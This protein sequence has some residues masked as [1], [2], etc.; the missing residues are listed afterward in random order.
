MRWPAPMTPMRRVSLAARARVEASA[1]REP[2]T[3]K[4]RRVAL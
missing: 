3:R 2:A 4:L 1:V